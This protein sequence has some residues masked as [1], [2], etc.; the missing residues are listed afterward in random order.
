ML[1]GV[2]AEQQTS[3]LNCTATSRSDLHAVWPVQGVHAALSTPISTQSGIPRRLSAATVS[4]FLLLE[5]R[6]ARPSWPL[7]TSFDPG[8]Q[9]KCTTYPRMATVDQGY[10]RHSFQLPRERKGPVNEDGT[11]YPFVRR[12]AHTL[13]NKSRI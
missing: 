4:F 2:R 8:L 10:H 1:S 13:L 7:G 5:A 3:F 6:G 12:R 9:R 11:A